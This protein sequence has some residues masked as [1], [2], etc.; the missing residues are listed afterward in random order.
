MHRIQRK[1][2]LSTSLG[3]SLCSKQSVS[4]TKSHSPAVTISQWAYSSSRVKTGYP[5]EVVASRKPTFLWEVYRVMSLRKKSE[6]CL[7]SAVLSRAVW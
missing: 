4:L 2:G 3:Q 6:P 1:W 5:K 7:H